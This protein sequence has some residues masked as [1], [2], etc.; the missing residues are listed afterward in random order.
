MASNAPMGGLMED[1]PKRIPLSKWNCRFPG[2]PWDERLASIVVVAPKERLLIT[3]E[4]SDVEEATDYGC[5][6]IST[7]GLHPLPG[8]HFGRCTNEPDDGQL[9]ER[10]LAS[11]ARDAFLMALDDVE[12]DLDSALVI[13]FNCDITPD[14]TGLYRETLEAEFES[15]DGEFGADVFWRAIAQGLAS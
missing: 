6:L 9:L 11:L 10:D 8:D 4:T 3:M 1:T 5:F 7:D 15:L 13:G 14:E 12:T 2:D